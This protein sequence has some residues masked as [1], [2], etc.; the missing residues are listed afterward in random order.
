MDQSVVKYNWLKRGLIFGVV[1]TIIIL[2]SMFII[3]PYIMENEIV[4]EWKDTDMKSTM[5]VILKFHR[6]NTYEF[7]VYR[8]GAKT[9]EIVT[10]DWG[11]WKRKGILI[12]T[13]GN[14]AVKL[15]AKINKEGLTL[16]VKNN[17]KEQIIL[18]KKLKY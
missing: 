9:D 3:E 18:L 5:K 14:S 4:G 16:K 12:L 6:D 2:L 1:V 17:F 7:D 15:T 8:L 10:S 11:T 13:E